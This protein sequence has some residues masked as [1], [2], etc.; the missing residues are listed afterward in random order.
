MAIS[1]G[2][3]KKYDEADE[4]DDIGVCTR[5]VWE[6]VWYEQKSGDVKKKN[7]KVPQEH[8]IRAFNSGTR[9]SNGTK[10]D[11]CE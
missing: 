7:N 11:N 10:T 1:K 3:Y 8:N 5:K 6:K 4:N 9:F 2:L